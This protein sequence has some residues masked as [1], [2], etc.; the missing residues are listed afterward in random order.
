MMFWT[1]ESGREHP[2]SGRSSY[3]W[4]VMGSLFEGVGGV[5]RGVSGG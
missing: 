5:G 4:M 1:S 2:K 3:K